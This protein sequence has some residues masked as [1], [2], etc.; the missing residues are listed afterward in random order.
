MADQPIHEGELVGI[1]LGPD[2]IA[3]RQVD[4]GDPH[5]AARRRDHALDDSAPVRRRDRRARPRATS[6]GRLD[7]DRDAVEPLLPVQRDIVAQR[8]DLGARKR[9]VDAFDLLQAQRVGARLLEI[10]EQM[11]QPLADRIDVP[12]GDDQG[13]A[14][15][16]GVRQWH[17]RHEDP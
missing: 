4:A 14:P 6:N 17:C 5:D 16:L 7:E 15:V 9:L 10:V 3:V 13:G 1:F 8:L 12:G 11:R 2:R